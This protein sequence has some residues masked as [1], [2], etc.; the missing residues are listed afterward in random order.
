MLDSFITL[1]L[2]PMVIRELLHF[3]ATD[4]LETY[5]RPVDAYKFS[6]YTLRCFTVYFYIYKLGST[7][8]PTH[9]IFSHCYSRYSSRAADAGPHS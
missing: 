7:S 8:R 1:L 3:A 5:R 6:T 9:V 2:E 4:D